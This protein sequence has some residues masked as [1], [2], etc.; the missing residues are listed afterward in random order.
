MLSTPGQAV[1]RR[2]DRLGDENLDLLGAQAWRF[3]LD[4]DLGRRKFGEHVVLGIPQ[5]K[6]AIAGER[7]SERKHDPAEANGEGDQ[8]GLGPR[9][10][11]GATVNH[12]RRAPKL[13]LRLLGQENLCA[14]NHDLGSRRDVLHDVVIVG[15]RLVSADR[16]ALEGIGSGAEVHPRPALPLHDGGV[17]EE[18]AFIGLAR[19]DIDDGVH[20]RQQ[21]TVARSHKEV[22]ES[23]NPSVCSGCW[24]DVVEIDIGIPRRRLRERSPGG[25]ARTT[26]GG[27]VT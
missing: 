17:L 13:A 9:R 25:S 1:D 24:R 14:P 6:T 12:C 16:V 23:L 26:P 4:R 11:R 5:C 20:P 15:D 27:S 22:T 18:H 8:R 21:A 2:F 19:G 3:G 7:T 10:R